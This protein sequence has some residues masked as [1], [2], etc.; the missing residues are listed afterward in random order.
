MTLRD[1]FRKLANGEVKA[2]KSSPAQHLQ[3]ED[4][5]RLTLDTD[6][7]RATAY[8]TVSGER[9]IPNGGINTDL[10]ATAAKRALHC[11]EYFHSG[12][13]IPSSLGG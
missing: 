9:L 6:F 11:L 10:R 12:R 4:L 13:R 1:I 3:A 7:E 2:G 8:L 5:S